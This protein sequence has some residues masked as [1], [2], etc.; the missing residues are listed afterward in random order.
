MMRNMNKLL[1]ALGA[2]ALAAMPAHGQSIL[3][4]PKSDQD[5][6]YNSLK[7][8]RAMSLPQI[9]QRVV[10][11]MRGYTYLGPE[12]RGSSYRLKFM[13]EGRVVWV[14]VDARTGRIIG[15]SGQ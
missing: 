6:A 4:P 7:E 15:R 5:R 12:F 3:N 9:E 11:R 1:L 2:A 14:D 8:G 13:K 10:P